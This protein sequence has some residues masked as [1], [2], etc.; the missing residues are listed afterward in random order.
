MVL[1]RFKA[2]SRFTSLTA[3]ALRVLVV[4]QRTGEFQE[5]PQ[6]FSAAGT[7][8]AISSP[9]P[10]EDQK[11]RRCIFLAFLDINVS[12][13]IGNSILGTQTF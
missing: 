3:V 11:C 4:S 10:P 9:K 12:R 8:Q 5:S 7:G 6:E 2:A 1:C 13:S